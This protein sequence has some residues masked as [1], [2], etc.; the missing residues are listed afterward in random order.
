VKFG[1]FNDSDKFKWEYSNGLFKNKK[2]KLYLGYS[3]RRDE[4]VVSKQ[5]FYWVVEDGSYIRS[6]KYNF[7][8]TISET[9][10][11]NISMKKKDSIEFNFT[12]SG[13]NF[14]KPPLRVKFDLNNLRNGITHIPSFTKNAVRKNNI[15]ILLIAGQSTRFDMITPKQLYMIDDKPIFVYSLEILVRTLDFV[16]IVTNSACK[17][18]VD[19]YINDQSRTKV[20]LVTNDINC[21]LESISAGLSYIKGTFE[22]NVQNVI[23]HDGARP[24]ITENHIRNLVAKIENPETFFA[25]YYLKLV[26]GL[27]YKDNHRIDE[28]DRENFIEICTPLAIHYELFSFLFTNYIRRENRIVWDF[29]PLLKLLKIDYELIE[30]CH[31]ELKKITTKDDTKN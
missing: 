23:I 22:E 10:L 18:E 31:R 8:L 20:H 6:A 5:K 21:R 4:I 29:I 7:Y 30:G 15:G 12:Q 16:V 2:K 25:Q 26:N 19:K 11:L 13:I 14:I 3:K 24:F 9:Y 28:V 1:L 17:E 27:L